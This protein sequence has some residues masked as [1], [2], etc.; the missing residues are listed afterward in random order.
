[1]A[2]INQ[3][4]LTP[5]PVVDLA[6]AKAFLRVD[7]NNDDTLI[8]SLIDQ[9]TEEAQSYT[10]VIFGEAVYTYEDKGN[11]RVWLNWPSPVVS[12]DSVQVDGSDI[13]YTDNLDGS[14]TITGAGSAQLFTITYTVGM[15]PAPKD[16]ASAILQRVKFGY[17]WGDDLPYD[18]LRFFDRI[19]FRYRNTGYFG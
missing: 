18:K 2:K 8:Q 14:L 17:D 4:S 13:E 15:D 10:G 6:E 12:I 16:V 9:A 19:L 1:M 11:Q 3:I 5:A 7:F